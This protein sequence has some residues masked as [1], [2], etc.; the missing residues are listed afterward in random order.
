MYAIVFVVFSLYL[1]AREEQLVLVSRR[2]HACCRELTQWAVMNKPDYEH[3]PWEHTKTHR[4][5]ILLLYN[6]SYRI[7]R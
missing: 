6:M 2:N 5:I 1:P 7:E 4:V 3:S